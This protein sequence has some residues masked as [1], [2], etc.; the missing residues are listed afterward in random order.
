PGA[1]GRPC[2]GRRAA[3]PPRVAPQLYDKHGA[4]TAIIDNLTEASVERRIAEA[5]SVSWSLPAEHRRAGELALA[6]F[7]RLYRGP[8]PIASGR[9]IARQIADS[10]WRYE[11]LTNEVELERVHYPALWG[12]LYRGWDLADVVRDLLR[13]RR[14]YRR[15]TLAHWQAAVEAVNV[16]L[17][18]HPGYVTLA[19]DPYQDGLRYRASGYITLQFDAPGGLWTWERARWSEIVGE[20]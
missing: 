17:Q 19:R 9:L 14:V 7:W 2:R 5:G 15:N 3:G 6:R 12:E 18:A 10:P 11:G 13:E 4:L 8:E 20:D 1:F 16:D